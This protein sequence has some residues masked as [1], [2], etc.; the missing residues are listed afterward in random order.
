LITTT[1]SLKESSFSEKEAKTT[2]LPHLL[3]LKKR[4]KKAGGQSLKY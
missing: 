3:F 2:E 1:P 4:S